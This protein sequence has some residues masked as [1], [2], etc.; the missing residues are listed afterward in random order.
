MTL[1]FLAIY[2]LAVCWRYTLSVD[3]SGG[4][5]NPENVRPPP[6]SQDADLFNELLHKTRMYDP[7]AGGS[8]KYQKSELYRQPGG[9]LKLS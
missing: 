5:T 2:R 9:E 6:E 1:S 7:R 8:R 4:S 3:T